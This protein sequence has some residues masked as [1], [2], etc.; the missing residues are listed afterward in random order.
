MKTLVW[1]VAALED[2][3]EQVA[4]IAADN[5]RNARLV[6]QRVDEAVQKLQIRSIGRPGRIPGIYEKTVYRTSLIIAY[7]LLDGGETVVIQRIIHAARHWPPGEW[8]Q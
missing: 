2:F 6:A 5:P 1:S 7:E 8:P 3:D 4:Y